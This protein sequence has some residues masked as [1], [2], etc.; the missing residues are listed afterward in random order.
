[1][2]LSKHLQNTASAAKRA[3]TTLRK[4]ANT[5]QSI[6]DKGVLLAAARIAESV[7][8]KTSA[9]AKTKRREE[10]AY[11]AFMQKAKIEAEK[12]IRSDWPMV[13]TLQKAA[14][15]SCQSFTSTPLDE[16]M[17][18][19]LYG[20]NTYHSLLARE[21]DEAISDIA[22]SVAYNSYQRKIPVAEAIC[23]PA[24]KCSSK[25]H[26]RTVI[27]MAKRVDELLA[28]EMPSEVAA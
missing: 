6:E 11:R 13:T 4:I 18:D 8:N 9:D 5:T 28:T 22:G 15:W 24:R 21:L 3:A 2:E 26:D 1:M 19:S 20:R 16:R 27:E 12:K 10:E 17:R 7:G 23:E 25:Y 14:I